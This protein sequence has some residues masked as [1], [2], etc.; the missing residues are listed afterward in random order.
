MSGEG[1]AQRAGRKEAAS[2]T[3]ASDVP[4][5]W[6]LGNPKS[7][8]ANLLLTATEYLTYL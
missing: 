1:A 5:L 3:R 8:T 4:R 6:S 2:P 7:V